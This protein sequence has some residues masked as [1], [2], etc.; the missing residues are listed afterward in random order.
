MLE[1]GVVHLSAIGGFGNVYLIRKFPVLFNSDLA[2]KFKVV[3]VADIYDEERLKDRKSIDDLFEEIKSSRIK[4]KELKP[5]I[6]KSLY[7]L[8]GKLLDRSL[9]YFQ[10]NKD[11]P[12]IPY[13]LFGLFDRLDGNAVVDVSAPNKY[14]LSLAE[15]VLRRN[16]SLLLEKPA[17]IS[18][19]E[20]DELGIL[21]RSSNLNGT[22]LIDAEHYSHYGNV[23]YYI[24]HFESYISQFGKVTGMEL[25]IR[26]DEDFSSGR[27]R[28]TVERSK[29]GGGIWLDTGIHIMAFLRNIGA[30]ID[31]NSAEVQPYKSLDKDIQ[32]AKYGETRM[33]VELDVKEEKNFSKNCHVKASV[34]KSFAKKDKSK[35]FVVYH[36]N[37]KVEMDI[38]TKELRVYDKKN[39]E[40]L[41]Q[42]SKPFEEDAFYN[43]FRDLHECITQDV[44]PLTS[45]SKALD[46]VRDVF[47][48]YDKAGSKLIMGDY[49]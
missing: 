30:G 18:S 43:V 35:C 6:E 19:R 4:E 28:E 45:L 32:D 1:N 8:K 11:S 37:G 2:S 13:E 22:K 29:S 3:S 15:Q 16:V 14:H 25:S 34:G 24:D 27:N 21:L 39:E 40:Y 10:L 9:P 38:V 26:E 44:A 49:N 17:V 47:R 48:V 33:D 42:S 7:I 36:I 12:V 41:L 5:E 46:N 31:W 23:R 20:A